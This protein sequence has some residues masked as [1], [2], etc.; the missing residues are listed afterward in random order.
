[1][2]IEKNLIKYFPHIVYEQ[3]LQFFALYDLYSNWNTKINLISRKDIE[4]LYER[5]VLHSLGIAQ[6]ISF[7]NHS[8]VLDV[9]TGG[10]FP[11]IPLAIFFPKVHFLLLDS[12]EKKIKAVKDIVNELK[13]KNVECKC[14]RVEYEFKQFD[15][16]VSRSVMSLLKLVNVAKKNISK[17][18]QNI[19]SNGFLC[20]KG[21][22]LKSELKPFKKKI[23]EYKLS[24]YFQEDFF[25]TKKVIYLPT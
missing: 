10:G 22:D 15:F 18:Q 12:I 20:L 24:N 1:M 19:L 14:L 13:L 21:G 17:K 7:C 5:H 2:F 23:I 11:G 4:N 3:R 25:K 16:I 9:G 6:V 8:S